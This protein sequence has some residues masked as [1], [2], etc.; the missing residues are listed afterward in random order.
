M[1]ETG[2]LFKMD[3][4]LNH[5]KHYLPAQAPL[6]DF[7]HHNTLHAFQ[8]RP[9]FQALVEA[10]E[11]FGYKTFLSLPEYRQLYKK[12]QVNDVILDRVVKKSLNSDEWK[13][14]ML[15]KSYLESYK[16]RIG[17][18]RQFWKKLYSVDLDL[19]NHG[20]LFRFVSN[21]LDQGVSIWRFPITDLGFLDAIRFL[22]KESFSGI[23]KGQ[24]AKKFLHESRTSVD[25]VL[26]ILVGEERLYEH[27]L[28]DQQLAHPGWSGM[29]AFVEDNPNSLIDKR[30]ITLKEFIF[31]E[32]LLEIDFLDQKYGETWAPLSTQ[33]PYK[34]QPL[35]RDV[36]LMEYDTVMRLWQEAYEWTHYDQVLGGIVEPHPKNKEQV[37]VSFQALFCIDDR[38]GSLRRYIEIEDIRSKTY[39]TP[40]FFGAAIYYKPM[41]GKFSMKVCPGSI[42]PQ[43]LIKE[44]SETKMSEKDFHFSNRT[45]SLLLGWVITHTIGFWS[46][47]R[48]LINIFLPKL[49]PATTHSFRHMDRFSK[50]TIERISETE[51]G[52][53]IG[54]SLE[55][56]VDVVE[57][58]LKSIGLVE[59]FA[60]LVYI[61]G[62]GA[63]SVN[64]THYAGYDCGACSGRP[65]SVNARTFAYMANHSEVRVL[66]KS[67]GI[68]IKGNTLFVSGLHDTTRDE[69]EFYD[70]D[71]PDIYR[72]ELHKDNKQVFFKAMEKNAKERARRFVLINMKMKDKKIHETVKLR[73]FSL[74]EPRPELNH[75]TNSLCIVG[76]RSLVNHLFL[77]RRAF[78]NSY[79]YRLD[80]S[81]DL[82]FSI[83]IAAAP[84][85][86][87]INLEYYFSRVDNLRLGAG[88]KLPHNVMGLIGVANGIDGDIRPGLPYQMV[89]VHD[90]LRLLMIIEQDPNIVLSTIKRTESLYEWFDNEWI[91]L[92][93]VE[94]D[95]KDIY[96][97]T[98]GNFV[99]Y[100]PNYSP[101]G[102]EDIDTLIETERE[103][104][105]VL[106][107][108]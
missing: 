3:N 11:I 91:N 49:S 38:E 104:I 70:D 41:H 45:H 15:N 95:T 29:V 76:D 14:R 88:S 5:I 53:S 83:L 71:F 62:H 89:E 63:S 67:K 46:A 84:V 66:L 75:S 100:E 25:D 86:A 24:R 20:F 106:I 17:E 18:L 16:G 9:F 36:L 97:F 23:L 72:S 37:D 47:I 55:E 73:S 22:D 27:Y 65:G 33:L 96:L 42:K 82:L 1:K 2:S 85:C 61:I 8:D 44:Y 31:F 56:M 64:N 54:Y 10:R 40:G 39:G 68:H 50:L 48:L 107:L 92:T 87:G 7:V 35:F 108:N 81:G 26:K 102:L 13:K 28:F 43:H 80:P 4:V 19:A 90:P 58:V 101:K 79:D 52:L 57:N 94:P 74:F 99:I 21:Y 32:C 60:P 12:G 69:I 30:K 98:K 78:M 6:K 103:N 34:I 105:P 59:N 93:V 51:E 77:D